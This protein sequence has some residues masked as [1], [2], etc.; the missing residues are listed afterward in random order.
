MLPTGCMSP[1]DP[2]RSEAALQLGALEVLLRGRRERLL[3]DAW[4]VRAIF[5][6]PEGP[7]RRAGFAKRVLNRAL[8]LPSERS[9]D[10]L[11]DAFRLL[12]DHHRLLNH[13][14]VDERSVRLLFAE[15]WQLSPSQQ[16]AVG[17]LL[18]ARSEAHGLAAGKPS[19]NLLLLAITA[20]GLELPQETVALPTARGEPGGKRELW[21]LLHLPDEARERLD[22]LAIS[23]DQIGRVSN[24]IK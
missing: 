16:R 1:L 5:A 4:T 9:A 3:H 6:S 23:I 13:A 11:V 20:A 8:A 17:R 24:T 22:R 21:R 2:P 12:E 18:R 10:P 7:W 15:H 19:S 14:R